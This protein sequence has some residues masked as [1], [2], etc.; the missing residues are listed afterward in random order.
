ME[1]I[2]PYLLPGLLIFYLVFSVGMIPIGYLVNRVGTDRVADS[3]FAACVVVLASQWLLATIWATFGPGKFLQRLIPC[4]L[5]ALLALLAFEQTR[6]LM[7]WVDWHAPI[8]PERV[9]TMHDLVA[10]WILVT[11]TLSILRL[12]PGFRWRVDAGCDER[13]RAL[14]SKS[15]RT[16]L[17]C[18][19]VTGVG[20]WIMVDRT[21]FWDGVISTAHR[22]SDTIASGLVAVIYS[23]VLALI[24]AIAILILMLATLSRFS[25]W[26]LYRRNWLLIPLLSATIAA[27]VACCCHVTSSFDYD[28]ERAQFVQ[29]ILHPVM[30]LLGFLLTAWTL[31]LAGYRL[32]SRKTTEGAN[33]AID[34]EATPVT[35]TDRY[36]FSRLTSLEKIA[37]IGLLALLMVTVPTGFRQKLMIETWTVSGFHGEIS[38]NKAGEITSITARRGGTVRTFSFLKGNE[39]LTR[40]FLD[41][42]RI[43]EKGMKSLERLNGDLPSGL[44]AL[45]LNNCTINAEHLQYI[46][47]F[48]TLTQLALG[49][50]R[51]GTTKTSVTDASLVHLKGLVNLTELS[52]KYAYPL[53]GEGLKHLKGLKKL[54]WLDVSNTPITDGALIHLRELTNLQGLNLEGTNIT[55]AAVKHLTGLTQL[56]KMSILSNRQPDRYG[57]RTLNVAQTKIS[58]T[59]MAILRKTF[60]GLVFE[61]LDMFFWHHGDI[62]EN[63]LLLS[64]LAPR[65]SEGHIEALYLQGRK[66][67]L[68]PFRQRDRQPIAF[69]LKYAKQLPH[70]TSLNLDDT[71]MVDE[72]MHHLAELTQ[73]E[74]LNISSSYVTDTGLVHLE[75]LTN[76]KTLNLVDTK[77]TDAGVAEL[78]KALPDCEITH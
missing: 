77:V 57:R 65:N 45:S 70:L 72:S 38:T 54:Q 44:Q 62:S 67:F 10:A 61:N 11:I 21:L 78:Q 4:F 3:L 55:D 46:A 13:P 75:G 22:L 18:L 23:L 34:P 6:C 20:T 76:L 8:R 66:S 1:K 59:G 47:G 48:T 19:L 50:N 32:R 64:I 28:N 33:T 31:G 9:V 69:M 71:N 49:G 41:E 26:L 17:L 14:S 42:Q 27:L 39:M 16:E 24:V 56:Q 37:V 68:D 52:L 40:L 53:T 73:L 51:F 7:F 30:I 74:Y 12:I 15:T 35:T 5:C 36:F 63:P 43:S 2:K 29:A 60:H 25:D 58:P